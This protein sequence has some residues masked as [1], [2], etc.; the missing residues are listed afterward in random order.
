MHEVVMHTV[1]TASTQEATERTVKIL[2][3]TYEK[4]DLKQVANNATQLNN[5]ERTQLVSL[6]KYSEDLFDGTLG[7]WAIEPVGLKP[8]PDSKP[9]N[10]KYYPV[11]IIN[12]ETFRKELKFQVEMGLIT[13]VQQNQYNTP[14]FIIPKKEGIVRFKT[15]YRR[16]NQKLLRNPY[17][18]P[19]IGDT[20]HQLEGLKYE[21][22]LDLNM[23]YYTI[24]LSP[25]SQDMMT[26][27]TQFGKFIYNCITMGM[28]TT[29]DIF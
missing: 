14:V 18:L 2:D 13:P 6:L 21:T 15:G 1:E 24:S 7:D 26:I 23:V 16:L 17:P 4:A 12:K 27:V 25:N 11:P 22:A 8:K 5:E 28:C 3:S 10:S 29:R 19:R 20:M 9:F